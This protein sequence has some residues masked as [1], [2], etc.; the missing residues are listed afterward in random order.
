[1]GILC[2]LAIFNINN[3]EYIL[4]KFIILHTLLSSL[5]F[6]LS[7]LIYNRTGT[8][9]L[10]IINGIWNSLPILGVSLYITVLLF[11]GLPFTVKFYLEFIL[12]CKLIYYNLY[13]YV[14][15]MFLIQ[16]LTIIFFF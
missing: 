10:N 16:L 15:F 6:F 7:E 12:M 14:L 3:T 9:Q 2:L 5:L 13:I 11:I 4:F 1:M 8:R